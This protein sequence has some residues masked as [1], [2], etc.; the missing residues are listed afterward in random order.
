MLSSGKFVGIIFPSFVLYKPP[1][2]KCVV[3][4]LRLGSLAQCS[5]VCIHDF[6]LSAVA[7]F[8]VILRFVRVSKNPVIS[9]MLHFVFLF[10]T[11]KT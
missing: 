1:V 11:G 4:Q 2:S 5:N 3:L 9:P 7:I 8:W 10:F 6:V